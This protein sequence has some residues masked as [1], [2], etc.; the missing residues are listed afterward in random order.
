M[1]GGPG[2][3]VTVA[4]SSHARSAAAAGRNWHGVLG[5]CLDQLDPMPAGATLG[6]VY[7]SEALCP[8]ADTIVRAL[9]ERTGIASWIGAGGR[10]V[11]G[12]PAG[13]DGEGM[14]VLV[15]A[16]PTATFAVTGGSA[17]RDAGAEV[18]LA[19]AELGPDGP[20]PVLAE[21]SALSASATIGGLSA[22]DRSPLQIAGNVMA[23]GTACL[24]FA[25][26]TPVCAGL[27]TA[28][29]PLGPSHRVTSA[30]D[31][32]I[33]ALD[34]RP[35]LAVL[36]EE[37]GDLFRRAGDRFAAS[38]WVADRSGAEDGPA[39]LRMRQIVAVDRDRGSL[40]LEGGRPGAE[41]RL[42]RPDPASSLARVRDL[43]MAQRDRLRDTVPIAA[44]YLASRHRGQ[45][46]FGPQVD[47]VAILRQELGQHLPL[48]GLVTDA[49]IFGGLAHEAAGVLMLL[50]RPR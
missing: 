13:A 26:G 19:H 1:P 3:R 23:G 42:M 4:A 38:L 37:L 31:G 11:L 9:R 44:I 47:E 2:S 27:A 14:A 7:L 35:A 29:S 36:T 16:L 21:L 12:G 20:K 25:P 28:G 8:M 10:G 5:A 24:A 41:L 46:L 49:E 48:I 50:G 6:F 39:T 30:L 22:A 45:S 15:A 18:I 43:A 40:R 33:L 34:G 32:E 17:P